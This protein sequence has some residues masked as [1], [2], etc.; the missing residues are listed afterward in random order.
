MKKW[1]NDVFFIIG[2][3]L[4]AGGLAMWSWPLALVVTGT[5]LIGLALVGTLRG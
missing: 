4:V 5:V 1:I 3:A 2:L